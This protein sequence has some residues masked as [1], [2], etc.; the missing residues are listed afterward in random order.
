MV[1]LKELAQEFDLVMDG[2][3]FWFDRETEK[4]VFVDNDNYHFDDN[5]QADENQKPECFL[6]NKNLEKLI[7]NNPDRLV[8][9]PGKYEFHD[10]HIMAV[11]VDEQTTGDRNEL[12]WDTIHGKGAFRM[13]RNLVERWDLLDDWYAFKAAAYREKSRE[14]CH[15]YDIEYSE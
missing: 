7:K 10:W 8:Q 12:L 13:F 1:S 3:D 14:W 5:E 15:H 4:V 6:I 2:A 11:F 9:L